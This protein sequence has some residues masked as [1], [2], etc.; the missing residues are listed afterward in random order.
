[1]QEGVSRIEDLHFNTDLLVSS[2]GENVRI[3]TENHD[4]MYFEKIDIPKNRL[5]EVIILLL[6]ARCQS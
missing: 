1:V 3:E 2:K 5:D 6:Q 4:L